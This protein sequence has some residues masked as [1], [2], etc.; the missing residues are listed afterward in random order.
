MRFRDLGYNVKVSPE[1]VGTH[2]TGATAEQYK[3]GF[4]LQD[5]YQKFLMRWKP[6]LVQTDIEVL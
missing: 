1:A 4:P 6:K 3:Q 5:N 2:Y